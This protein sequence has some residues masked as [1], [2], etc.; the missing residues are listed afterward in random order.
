[1]ALPTTFAP[2]DINMVLIH[3]Q[4]CKKELK[5]GFSQNLPLEINRLSISAKTEIGR[6]FELPQL[7]EALNK[8]TLDKL[9]KLQAIADANQLIRNFPGIKIEPEPRSMATA[10]SMIDTELEYCK[11]EFGKKEKS[12]PIEVKRILDKLIALATTEIGE[13]YSLSIGVVSLI[14]LQS[15]RLRITTIDKLAIVINTTMITYRALSS[16]DRSLETASPASPVAT[17]LTI[18]GPAAPPAPAK[19]E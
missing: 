5:S 2:S 9:H 18:S 14:D 1:M 19:R 15:N 4:R 12:S 11:V 16:S 3:L 10:K 13:L 7:V 6:L 17:S 8:T